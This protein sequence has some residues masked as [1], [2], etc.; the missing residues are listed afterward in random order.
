[1]SPDRTRKDGS[2]G[3]NPDRPRA[4]PAS[5]ASVERGLTGRRELPSS[6][7]ATGRESTRA[8][9]PADVR[10][11]VRAA[12]SAGA[13]AGG[14][15]VGEVAARTSW[16]LT[17]PGRAGSRLRSSREAST[18]STAG[19][20]GRAG[21][22]FAVGP[23]METEGL[24]FRLRLGAILW[25]IG[26]SVLLIL[27][28]GLVQGLIVALTPWPVLPEAWVRVVHVV[29]VLVGGWLAGT[30]AGCRGW[31]HGG[32][33]G[34]LY[35]LGVAWWSKGGPPLWDRG[36]AWWLAV[37]AVAGMIGGMIGAAWSAGRRDRWP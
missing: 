22:F 10:P 24:H 27:L 1:M 2:W 36:V 28:V 32:L 17:G 31:A 8:A 18:R 5:R 7:R 35:G 3:S 25:G 15:A 21:A 14:P 37:L 26:W 19:T 30:R 6:P 4:S 13:G 33:V 34:L 16:R 9:G 12:A 20:S 29:V 23:G 11:N